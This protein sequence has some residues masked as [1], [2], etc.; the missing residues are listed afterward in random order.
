MKTHLVPKRDA[1]WDDFYTI[2]SRQ[3]GTQVY[4]EMD[5]VRDRT[6]LKS[7]QKVAKN[8]ECKNVL[9]GNQSV[10]VCPNFTF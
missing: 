5:S 9:Q 10:L 1:D 8:A 6:E 7:V 3:F 2:R 4:T